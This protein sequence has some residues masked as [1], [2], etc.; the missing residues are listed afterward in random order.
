MESLHGNRGAFYA[1]GREREASEHSERSTVRDADYA[2][3]WFRPLP[4][5]R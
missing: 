1:M 5:A 3:T 4:F 2:L